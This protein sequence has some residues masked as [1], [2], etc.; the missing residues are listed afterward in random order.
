MP[1]KLIC[2]C[3][4]CGRVHCERYAEWGPWERANIPVADSSVYPTVLYA[5]QPRCCDTC[6]RRNRPTTMTPTTTLRL[7][8]R[9][10]GQSDMT[11]RS[12]GTPLAA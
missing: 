2:L 3:L 1:V 5:T 11:L 9:G 8:L 6:L 7:A 10:R 12:R 4:P